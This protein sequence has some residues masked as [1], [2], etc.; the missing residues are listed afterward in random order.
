L[1]RKRNDRGVKNLQWHKKK[2][3]AHLGKAI[4]AERAKN[5]KDAAFHRQEMEHHLL[6]I[7]QWRKD[8]G[9]EILAQ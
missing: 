7:K 5:E 6:K 9:K 4:L 2:C 8:H 3:L 1:W